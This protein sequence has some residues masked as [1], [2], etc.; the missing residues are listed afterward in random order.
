[1]SVKEHMESGPDTFLIS[2]WAQ[3]QRPLYVCLSQG[4]EITKKWYHFRLSLKIISDSP[5]ERKQ[6]AGLSLPMQALPKLRWPSLSPLLISISSLIN[7]KYHLTSSIL[8]LP[9]K[10]QWHLSITSKVNY[11]CSLVLSNTSALQTYNR[12]LVLF[13]SVFKTIVFNHRVTGAPVWGI[14]QAIFTT[15]LLPPYLL[16]TYIRCFWTSIV[17][18]AILWGS[19]Y[20]T[21]F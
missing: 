5:P 10:L 21:N 13:F 17:L 6:R 9:K 12:F 1:M 19:S 3:G 14:W 4:Q 16:N 11:F 20:Y 15:R 2:L 8:A 7:D 18:K